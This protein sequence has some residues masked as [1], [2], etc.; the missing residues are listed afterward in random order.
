MTR[1]PDD[2]DAARGV[3]AGVQWSIVGWLVVVAF[4]LFMGY[5]TRRH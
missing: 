4:C 2:L 5:C 1:E 3:A